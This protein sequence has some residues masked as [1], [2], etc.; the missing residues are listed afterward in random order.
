[1]AYQHGMRCQRSSSESVG[2]AALGCP[3]GRS[4]ISVSI[5]AAASKDATSM[6][7]HHLGFHARVVVVLSVDITENLEGQ[8][9]SAMGRSHTPNAKLVLHSTRDLRNI[10]AVVWKQVESAFD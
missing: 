7:E 4:P 5:A 1:M 6:R 10:V 3:A 9:A 2:T 8:V